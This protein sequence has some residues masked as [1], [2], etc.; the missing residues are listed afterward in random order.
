[1]HTSPNYETTRRGAQEMANQ[2]GHDVGIEKRNEF[3]ATVYSASYLPKPENR[4][5]WELRCEVVQ[6][7]TPACGCGARPAAWHGSRTGLRSFLCDT[8]HAAAL[9]AGEIEAD[10]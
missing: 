3:G 7:D 6:P 9:E 1:M 4:C 2:S 10:D 8:C 5:G